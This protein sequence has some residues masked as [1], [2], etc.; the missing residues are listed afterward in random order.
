MD[1]LIRRYSELAP[2]Y[3][4]IVTEKAGYTAHARVPQQVLKLLGPLE[5]ASIL[6]LACGTG[7][8]SDV[9]FEAGCEVTGI[10]IA[11]GMIEVAKL[12]P[13]KKLLCQSIED[14][15]DV[16]DASFDAVV[17]IGVLEFIRAPRQLLEQISRKLRS[18]GICGLTVPRRLPL[19]TRL[20][21]FS[22]STDKFMSFVD[23]GCFEVVEV[24]EFFGYERQQERV[25]YKA[26]YLRGS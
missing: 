1:E 4:R 17:A 22:Y 21:I 19:H 12:R 10:D 15:L 26:F 7:L 13:F 9:F 3:D 11:P 25:E 18:G 8:S 6:D 5:G 20:D 2:D 23:L 14:T 16:P 24:A